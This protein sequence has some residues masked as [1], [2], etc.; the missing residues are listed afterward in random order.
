[1]EN[2]LPSKNLYLDSPFKIKSAF[3]QKGFVSLTQILS[4]IIL[5]VLIIG[6]G[7]FYIYGRPDAPPEDR[8]PV[9]ATVREKEIYQ[10]DLEEVT[11]AY[12]EVEGTASQ[13]D[14]DDIKKRVLDDLILEEVLSQFLIAKEVPTASEEV[15]EAIK[16]D[17]A[18]DN[19][20]TQHLYLRKLLIKK[21]KV[22]ESLSD[23]EYFS[24]SRDLRADGEINILIDLGEDEQEEVESEEEEE[25]GEE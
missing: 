7:L 20:Y 19:L 13:Q 17:G 14:L 10:K 23:F 22:V 2:S 1:M 12:L 15:T 18:E 16:R 5:V 9:V 11:G 21:V 4:I 6:A 8:G 24:F 3:S 25:D